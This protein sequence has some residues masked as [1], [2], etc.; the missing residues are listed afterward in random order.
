[1]S[2][3]NS[4]L[5]DNTTGQ[6]YSKS[7]HKIKLVIMKSTDNFKQVRCDDC[8]ALFFKAIGIHGTIEVKCRKCGKL[9]AI[10]FN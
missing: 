2:G 9:S 1:M 6:G 5:V 10:Q 7:R 8:N 4:T 3:K